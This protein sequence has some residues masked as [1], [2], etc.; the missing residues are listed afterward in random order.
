M[1]D[2][3]ITGTLKYV[4]DY[5]SAFSGDEASGN[6]IALRIHVPELPGATITAQVIGGVHDAV[7]LDSDGILVARISSTSQK[8]QFVASSGDLEPVTLT[9]ALTGL[10]LNNS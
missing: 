7:T 5:S 2:G 9:Y 10:T 6:Y 1:G 3:A 8:L 4:S